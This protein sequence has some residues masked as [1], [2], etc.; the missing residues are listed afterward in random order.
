MNQLIKLFFIIFTLTSF[1][2]QAGLLDLFNSKGLLEACDIEEL[3]NELIQMGFDPEIRMNHE[4]LT[5]FRTK[6]GLSIARYLFHLHPDLKNTNKKFDNATLHWATKVIW[7]SKNKI[8]AY[9][10]VFFDIVGKHEELT[11]LTIIAY[12]KMFFGLTKTVIMFSNKDQLYAFK[13]FT[14]EHL[15][16]LILAMNPEFTPK[17]VQERALI[18]REYYFEKKLARTGKRKATFEEP[19]F[20]ITGHA[21]VDNDYLYFGNQSLEVKSVIEKLL[22]FGLPH[23]AIISLE[24]CYSACSKQM[25]TDFTKEEILHFFKNNQLIDKI[26]DPVNSMLGKYIKMLPPDF[27]GIVRGHL[28]M[29]WVKPTSDVYMRNG[30]LLQKGMAVRIEANDGFIN[31]RKDESMLSINR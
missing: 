9:L 20:L 30:K 25:H 13:E 15:E 12:E 23:D 31:L 19:V 18:F 8:T 27:K 4:F 3:E 2:V 6:Y 29:V 16:P 17:N 14:N 10:P 1:S 26:G 21:S 24:V 28:G 11:L 22:E 7:S 5:A